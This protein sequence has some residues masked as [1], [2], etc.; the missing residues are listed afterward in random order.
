MHS[1]K[2]SDYCLFTGSCWSLIVI[3]EWLPTECSSSCSATVYVLARMLIVCSTNSIHN[4]TDLS[5][6]SCFSPNISSVSHSTT[7][8]Y[9]PPTIWLTE[10]NCAD[11][12]MCTITYTHIRLHITHALPLHTYN[13]PTVCPTYTF[14][15][16]SSLVATCNFPTVVD[17]SSPM[18]GRFSK[19][20]SPQLSSSRPCF[21]KVVVFI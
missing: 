14:Y 15:S 20:L 7:H 19:C 18:D 4:I 17:A 2:C 1:L 16:S 13:V 9:T 3:V 11:A 12:A 6:H 21:H 5:S 8:V 10:V